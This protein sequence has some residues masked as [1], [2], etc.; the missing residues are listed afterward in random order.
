MLMSP[1]ARLNELVGH[2]TG[3]NRLWLSP[4]DPVRESDTTASIT[5]AAAG[6]FAIVRYAWVDGG[7]PQDGVLMVRIASEPGEVD[8]VWADSWHMGKRFMLCRGEYH[9]EGEISALGTYAAPPGPDWG[10]R[11][12]LRAESADEMRILMYNIS[13][14]GREALAVDA[15]YRRGDAAQ[16]AADTKGQDG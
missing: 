1:Q 5:L 11:I 2:W 12:V 4:D 6:V 9:R 15:S 10:W 7:E 3:I 16:Q 13:P 14:E 8:V